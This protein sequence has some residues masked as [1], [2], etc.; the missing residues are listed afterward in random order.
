MAGPVFAESADEEALSEVTRALP[1]RFVV[2]DKDLK[3][4]KESIIVVMGIL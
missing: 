2:V 3:P 4:L 1:E